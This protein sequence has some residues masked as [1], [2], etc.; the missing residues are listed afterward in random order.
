MTSKKRKSLGLH[1]S[2]PYAQQART[3]TFYHNDDDLTGSTT[4]A[5]VSAAASSSSETPQMLH[6][7]HPESDNTFSKYIENDQTDMQDDQGDGPEVKGKSGQQK[8]IVIMEE[9]LTY[10]DAYLQELLRH[11]GREGRQVT[12]YADCGNSG[13]FSCYDCTYNM[14]Y[15]RDCLVNR[16]HLIPLH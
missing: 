14:H 2:H 13:D 4:Q 11:D 5:V 15:C 16:H 1:I 10:Q 7:I 9:W 12:F 8:R 3:V 6:S